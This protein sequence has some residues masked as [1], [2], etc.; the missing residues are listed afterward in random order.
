MFSV[1]VLGGIEGG[2]DFAGMSKGSTMLQDVVQPPEQL[3]LVI[4]LHLKK[5][6]LIHS[7][8]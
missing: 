8:P 2:S 1:A 7:S 4:L 6:L 5:C 3:S